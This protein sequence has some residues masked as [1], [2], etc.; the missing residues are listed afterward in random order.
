MQAFRIAPMS[1][2]IRIVTAIAL[3]IPPVLY[4]LAAIDPASPARVTLETSAA[5]VLLLFAAVWCF[6]RPSFVGVS[7]EGLL[8]RFPLRRRTVPADRITSARVL[9]RA[10]FQQR[11][12]W[13]FRIGVGGLWGV[14]GWLWTRKRGLVEIYVTTTDRWILVEREGGRDLLL[15][16]ADP[17]AVVRALPVR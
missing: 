2:S 7:A 14:F 12:G 10:E 8:V 17:D 15:S 9:Q 3:A 5:F 16:P 6:G 13:G 4:A 1:P 11:Y